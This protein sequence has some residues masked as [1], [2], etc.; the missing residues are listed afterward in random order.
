MKEV[1]VYDDFY[2]DPLGLRT[3]ALD[4]E[5]EQDANKNY[6]GANSYL[7]M[8]PDEF[9]EFFSHITGEPIKPIDTAH[10]GG[11]RIQNAGEQGKQYIHVDLPNFNA[12][13]AGV[14]YLSLP[15]HYTKADGTVYDSGSKFWKHRRTGMEK[16]P[17]DTNYLTSIGINSPDELRQFMETEG[18]DESLWINTFSVPI[19]FNRLIMFRSNLWH[20]QGEL[21]GNCKENGRLIQT[22]F[23]EPDL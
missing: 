3:I 10:T 11:F 22:F 23:F 6:P 9:K 18:L 19:K 12:T 1:I 5:Y 21:F 4:T 8:F 2:S 20:S 16:M 7:R 13:W 17:Y 14:C 15:E